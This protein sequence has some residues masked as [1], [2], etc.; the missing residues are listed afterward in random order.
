MTN[1]R[2]VKAIGRGGFG[3][4]EEV[5]DENGNRYAKKMFHPAAAIPS[6]EHEKLRKRFKREVLTQ[7]SLGGNAIIPVIAHELSG[8]E[9]WFIMP[10]AESTYQEQIKTDKVNGAVEIGPIAD[11]MNGLQC[12]H[13]KGYVHR[14]LNPNNILLH[15]GTWKLSDLGAVLPPSGGTTTL[16]EDTVI[17]TERYCAPEQR[18]N[19]HAAQPAADVYSFGCILHDIFG[20][21]TRT[22]YAK[23]TAPGAM[24]MIIEKCTEHNPSKR[25]ALNVLRSLVLDALFEEGGHCKV[26]DEQ[27]EEWLKRLENI[28]TW[29]DKDYENFG[30]FFASLNIKDR[31]DG[32][33]NDWVYSLSTPFL[34]RL[35][36]EVL[37]RIMQRKDGISGAIA[38]KYCDWAGN[39]QFLFNFADNVCLRLDKI[40]ENGTPVEKA[41][42]FAALVRLGYSHNRWFVMGR[43]VDRVKK[44]AIDSDLAK[45]LTIEIQTEELEGCFKKCL[46]EIKFDSQGIAPELAKL[47]I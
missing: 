30:R 20:T 3:I 17:Y 7:E 32:H 28:E 33:E 24:G 1:Y 29:T 25:P 4:V 8:T 5:E 41:Y 46:E 13:D 18:A 37:T 31:C 19:F 2:T 39:T 35:P 40:F 15:N 23:H 44:Q 43:M 9:P 11:I 36:L 27:A 22:P 10:L 16:T 47:L 45:R 21:G 34:T 42:A 26:E 6:E 38:E 12:L 14:D